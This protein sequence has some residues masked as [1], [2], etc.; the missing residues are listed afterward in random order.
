MADLSKLSRLLRILREK[1]SVYIFE[2]IENA[3]FGR[4]AEVRCSSET[5]MITDIPMSLPFE[6]VRP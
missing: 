3:Q 2:T 4:R 6:L 5:K 1:L